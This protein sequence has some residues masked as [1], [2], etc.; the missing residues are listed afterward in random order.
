MIL[1]EKK[2]PK[3]TGETLELAV[4]RG[5]ELGI[6]NFVV[7]SN[8]GDTAFK[9]LELGVTGVCVTHHTG[10]AG[11]GEQEMTPEAAEKLQ[12]MGMRL[13]TATHLMGGI[14]RGV[15]NKLGGSTPARIIT[16]TLKMFGQGTKVCVEIAVMALDSGLV[17]Y[18]EEII[19]IGGSG[20]G[21]DTAM[22]LQPAHAKNF[23]DCAIKEIICK[24]WQR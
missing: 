5:R 8:M 18:G 2:G 14:D 24:P 21:A 6:N 20:R 9:L 12:A 23:F 16:E 11:P 15:E 22:V 4:K 3:N 7:A 10:Y 19:A 17:P 1:W 13:L